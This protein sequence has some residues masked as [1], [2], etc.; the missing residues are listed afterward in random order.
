MEEERRYLEETAAALTEAQKLLIGIGEE[1]SR[2]AEADYEALYSLLAPRDYFIV[3]SLTDGVLWETAPDRTRMVAPCGNV[4]WLQCSKAC[5]RDIWEEHEVPA[6]LCPHCG[7]PLTANTIAAE[8]YLEEGYLPQWEAY[9]KWQTGTLNRR[10]V[11]LELGEGFRTPTVMRW[12]FE[13]IAFFNQKSH[14]YR[15][16]RELFQVPKEIGARG[17][18]IP[19]DSVEFMRKLLPMTIQRVKMADHTPADGTEVR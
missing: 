2:A 5:R 13:K 12:P 17:T 18:G 11:L 4:H 9:K 19:M 8:P 1:W 3:T 6:G 7:A 16:R 14:L 10:L 15:I